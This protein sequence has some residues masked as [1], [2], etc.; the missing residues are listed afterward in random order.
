MSELDEHFMKR[1]LELARRGAGLVSPNPAVGAVVVRDG[2]IVGEGSFLYEHLKHAEVYALEQAG[3]QARGATLYCSLEPCCFQGRTPPCTDAVIEAGVARA[4]I[5]VADPHPRVSG[6]GLEQLRN[7]GIAVEVG[8]LEEESKRINETVFKFAQEG[9]PFIHAVQA[10]T[11]KQAGRAWTPST[12]FLET[13]TEYD[14]ILLE[15]LSEAAVNILQSSL[16]RHRHRPLI[17]AGGRGVLQRAGAMLPAMN[18]RE[19]SV[20]LELPMIVPAGERL[21]DH[22]IAVARML[23]PLAELRAVSLLALT[24]STEASPLVHSADKLTRVVG[25]ERSEDQ[26][27]AIASEMQEIIITESPGFK[28]FTGYPRHR[29]E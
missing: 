16:A 7:A 22:Q 29:E 6:R 1:A 14:A 8:L 23:A 26:Q 13:A 18:D 20:A 12:A 19:K 24:A 3:E 27:Q 10:E 4:V 11:V 2:R 15:S 28:E 21:A 17:V 9:L 25:S 5:A